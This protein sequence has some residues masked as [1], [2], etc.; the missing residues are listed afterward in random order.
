VKMTQ[1]TQS[2]SGASYV[3]VTKFM[4]KSMSQLVSHRE[5]SQTQFQHNSQS[6]FRSM[7]PSKIYA[8]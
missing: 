5:N 4:V 8:S 3:L 7:M 1:G 2:G 6:A